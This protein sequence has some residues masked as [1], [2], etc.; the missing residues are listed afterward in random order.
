MRALLIASPDA[1]EPA[2]GRADGLVLAHA[3]ARAPPWLAALRR[4]PAAPALYV[5]VAPGAPDL[6][7]ALAL[8]PDGIV[9]P[10]V[11]D[12]ADLARLGCRLAVHEAEAGL[13]DGATRIL[14]GLGTACGLL[15]IGTLPGASPRLAALF[16]EVSD[17]A[18]DLGLEA[19]D[20]TEPW[21]APIAQARGLVVLAAASAGVPALVAASEAAGPDAVLRAAESARRDGFRG[22]FA[23]DAGAAALLA[24]VFGADPKRS[25]D[26]S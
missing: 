10:G 7:A 5:R 15:R 12:G 13:P 22:G 1:D 3:P 11:E 24:R 19:R 18:R 17:L 26:P 2:L 25:E 14:A 6:D 21:P 9:L 20:P 23:R 8:A 4:R 16:C